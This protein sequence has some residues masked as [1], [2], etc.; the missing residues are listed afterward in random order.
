MPVYVWYAMYRYRR[1]SRSWLRCGSYTYCHTY[2]KPRCEYRVAHVTTQDNAENVWRATATSRTAT[3]ATATKVWPHEPTSTS[4]LYHFSR[5]S[6]AIVQHNVSLPPTKR[7]PTYTERPT[8][9]FSLFYV[10][11]APPTTERI[12][13]ITTANSIDQSNS[14][15]R[16]CR[17]N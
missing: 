12:S 9:I 1:C 5:L 2:T 11:R 17:S 8:R 16:V 14:G 7:S 10:Q 6:T 4:R 13:N 3:R 15:Q